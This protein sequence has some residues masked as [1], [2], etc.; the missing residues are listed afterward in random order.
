[1]PR[2]FYATRGGIVSGV[3]TSRWAPAVARLAGP[4]PDSVPLVWPG[5]G[6]TRGESVSPVYPTAP[7]AALRDPV[8]YE[9]LALVDLVRVGDAP[10]RRVAAE[11]IERRVMGR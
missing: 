8:V 1:V 6:E 3:P 7:G 11:L 4:L 10:D 5:G 9:L 2:I